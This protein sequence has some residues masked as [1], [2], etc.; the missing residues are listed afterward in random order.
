MYS[1]SQQ[2]NFWDYRMGFYTYLLPFIIRTGIS[3]PACSWM[4]KQK[5]VSELE[6]VDFGTEMYL[7]INRSSLRLD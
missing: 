5:K 4:Q 6:S 7:Y 2:L 1:L 3:S